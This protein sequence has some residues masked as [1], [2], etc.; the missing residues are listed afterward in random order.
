MLELYS[1]FDYAGDGLTGVAVKNSTTAFDYKVTDA[2]IY[3]N[4]G[5]LIYDVA[6]WSDFVKAQ[7]VDKDN[8]LGYGAGVILSEFI[9]KRYVNPADTELRL[10]L[11]YAGQVPQ[12]TY[13]RI[14]YTNTSETTDT[15]VA[16]SLHLHKRAS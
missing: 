9:T 1:F 14:S 6:N 13:L 10:E 5:V 7:V 15:K 8:V 12:N 2:G 3:T 16:V 4:G 11:P